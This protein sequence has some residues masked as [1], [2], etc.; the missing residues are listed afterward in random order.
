LVTGRGGALA[1]LEKLRPLV[2]DEDVVVVGTRADDSALA[3]LGE[4]GIAA[5]PA[6]DVLRAGA[7][8]TAQKVLNELPLADLDG[9]WVHCDVDVL[10]SALM[11]AVDTPEPGGLDF[12]HLSDLLR[13]LLG[14]KRA[15]G[16][17]ITI[18]DPDLD[19]TG[20]LA[21]RLASCICDAFAQDTSIRREV[22]L[23][24]R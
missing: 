2:R 6:E 4:V 5:H 13:G 15:V 21:K 3:E 8:V 14:D 17:E 11:P 7:A 16:L 19:E 12:G 24:C 9:F 22:D 18:F 20:E 1:S 10:D 23:G